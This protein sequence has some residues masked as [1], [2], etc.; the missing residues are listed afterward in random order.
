LEK[1]APAHVQSLLAQKR[2]H[3]LS[4]QTVVSIRNVSRAALNQALRWGLISRNTATLVD[5]PRIERP[6]LRVLSAEEANRLLEAAKG[7]RFEAVDIVGL[8]RGFVVVS[9]RA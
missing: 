6:A 7:E 9:F 3:K 4:P 1:L 5:A 2:L 8:A